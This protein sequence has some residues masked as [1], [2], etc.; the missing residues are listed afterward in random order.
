MNTRMHSDQATL[1]GHI[2]DQLSQILDLEV[3]E[4]RVANHGNF[5]ESVRKVLV[6]VKGQQARPFILKKQDND[7]AYRLYQQYLKPY[8][9]NSPEEYGYI[10]W[11]G[12][13]FLV[14]DY[15]KHAPTNWDN[16]ENYWIALKWLIKKDLITWQNFESVKKMDCL[17]IMPYHGMDYWLPIFEKWHMDSPGNHQA[18]EVWRCVHAHRHRIIEYIHELDNTGVQ[19]VVHGDFSID[20]MLFGEDAAEGELYVIDW[21]QPH[22]SSVTQD[23]VSLIDNTPDNLKSVLIKTYRKHIDFYHFDEIFGKAKVLRDFGYLSWM[24]WM[25]NVGHK[26][27]ITPQ[28]LDRVAANLILSLDEGR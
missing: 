26:N 25:I 2:A 13:R 4:V 7:V 6:F 3:R 28:E 5:P 17:G 16:F 20:N 11:D 15:I 24:A 21:T 10:E 19:T 22:I 8:H 18:D 23:L 27:E 1:P 12:Q 9:L 14:M